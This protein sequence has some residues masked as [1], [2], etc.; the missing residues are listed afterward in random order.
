MNKYFHLYK[1]TVELLPILFLFTRYL[2]VH[3]ISI[4]NLQS[5][6]FPQNYF[7][8]ELKTNNPFGH[9]LLS[10]QAILYLE[11]EYRGQTEGVK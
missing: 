6:Y 9:G 11:G 1:T 4:T 3:L 5:N 7:P 10:G 8:V 2:T